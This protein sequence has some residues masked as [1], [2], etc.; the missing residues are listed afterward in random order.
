[1]VL[2]VLIMVWA[3]FSLPAIAFQCGGSFPWL[4][5]PNRCTGSGAL[6]YP[7]LVFSILLD[8]WLA[9]A[10]WSALP[11]MQITR[12]ERQTILGLFGSR[13]LTCV[14]GIAQLALLAPALKDMNQPRA[15]PNPTVLK[16]LVM[17]ASI[18]TATIPCLYR[19]LATYRPV[20]QAIVYS[21]HDREEVTTPLEEIKAPVS[22]ALPNPKKFDGF[23]K[24]TEVESPTSPK[25]SLGNGKDDFS[26]RFSL[27]FNKE[28]DIATSKV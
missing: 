23:V 14:L 27:A 7:T 2:Q 25:P 1:M 20:T 9:I 15:M 16:Q 10:P 11:D 4:Y 28:I 12:K 18:L 6:W 19:A 3:A 22:A 8:A 17:N 26:G 21:T 13:A 5:L 24:E